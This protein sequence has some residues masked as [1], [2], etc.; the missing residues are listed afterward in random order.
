MIF[1]PG[2]WSLSLEG[3]LGQKTPGLTVSVLVATPRLV[4]EFPQVYNSGV[5]T[6]KSFI[7]LDIF[8]KEKRQ[9]NYSS[10]NHFLQRFFDSKEDHQSDGH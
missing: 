6:T 4:E 8:D 2:P 1:L 7:T 3:I 10:A 9:H 5:S